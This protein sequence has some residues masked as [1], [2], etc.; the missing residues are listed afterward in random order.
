MAGY[1]AEQLRHAERMDQKRARERGPTKRI[2]KS[3]RMMRS[4]DTRAVMN[5]VNSEGREVLSKDG[6]GY[7]KDMERR[8]PFIRGEDDTCTC[9]SAVMKNRLGRVKERTIYGAAG[10]VAVL[11]SEQ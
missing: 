2:G 4:I 7:W 6:E 1:S 9:G 11:R 8:H 3:G 10:E 5:A